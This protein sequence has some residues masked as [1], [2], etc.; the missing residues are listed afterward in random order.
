[1]E[2]RQLGDSK[3]KASVITFGA[4]AIGGAMW[5]GTDEEASIEA[6]RKS[7]E[8]GVTSIDTA[9]IYGF[10]KSEELVVKAIV[11]QRDKVQLMTKF[12][13]VWE[14]E[15]G[16][17]FFDLI[18]GGK[19][20]KIYRNARKK[21]II[22]ECENSL[23]RLKTDYIDL[24]QCHWRDN[25]LALDE[26]M[27]ALGQLIKDG[28]ILAAGVSNFTA[29]E[30]AEGSKIT[31]I[32]SVQPPYSMV[33]RDI[34]KELLPYCLANNVGVIVYSPLQR[35]VLT[36]KFKPD[37]K[38]PEEDHRADQPQFTPENIERINK[39]LETIKPIADRYNATVGQLVICWTIAQPG[40]SAAIVGARDA[41]QAEQN[42][43]AAQ[44]KVSQAD[45]DLISKRLQALELAAV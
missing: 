19:A 18:D 41:A 30:I 38:F 14:F 9:P 40:V 44:L 29:A 4:W 43:K 1:M 31:P 15:E 16:E 11:G 17:Y 42:A 20:H 3:V 26:T 36:G 7:I 8:L 37:H 28:K 13:L 22:R 5:G 12:G 34:E 32:A 21:N 27:E 23:K 2:Y 45:I 35:G 6:I 24:Y 39:F 10:G 25:S 33:N